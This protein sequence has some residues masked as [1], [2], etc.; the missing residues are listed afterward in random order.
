MSA[1]II[2][3]KSIAKG[4]TDGLKSEI[5]LLKRKPGL[6]VVLVG[7][8]PASAVYVGMKEKMSKELGIISS[9]VRLSKDATQQ[10][11]ADAVSKINKDNNVDGILVQLPIPKHLDEKAIIGLIEPNKDVD[12]IT[13]VNFGNLLLGDNPGHI[14]CTPKGIMT[15]IK[16]TGIE[17]KGKNAVVIGRSNI[18][19]KPVALL[20]MQE[21]ATI[22]ICHSRTKDIKSFTKAADI[23]VVAIGKEKFLTADMVKDGA[24]IIDVGTNRTTAGLVGDVDFE[25]VKNVA[26]FI[27]PVPKGVGPMTIAMLMQNCVEA[28]KRRQR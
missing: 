14:P 6:T 15:L 9:V 18:V 13:P 20:L 26:G 16:S 24:V 25:N 12:G 21:H 27:T 22:T 4:I 8:D 1:Q 23:V 5:A 2:D 10:E 3:G 19:G 17:I 28:A 7:D 11:V